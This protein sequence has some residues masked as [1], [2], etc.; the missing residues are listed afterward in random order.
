MLKQID[1]KWLLLPG[2]TQKTTAVSKIANFHLYTQMQY[3]SAQYI[4]CEVHYFWDK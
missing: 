4:Y 3:T 1:I 2:I